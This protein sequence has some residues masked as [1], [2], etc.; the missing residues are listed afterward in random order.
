MGFLRPPMR[1]SRSRTAMSAPTR[2]ACPAP[3]RRDHGAMRR[4]AGL[5]HHR[6]EV[7][8]PSLRN[9]THDLAHLLE[10][11]DEL[12]DGLNVGTR[13]TGDA[14]PARPLDQLGMTPLLRG[15]RED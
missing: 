4:S 1:V 10:L 7:R 13:A 14:Q 3:K 15:H 8:H 12:L 6:A 5:A 9:L 11:L 2:L